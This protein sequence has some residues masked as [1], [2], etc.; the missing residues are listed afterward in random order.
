[1][2]SSQVLWAFWEY[3]RFPYCLFGEVKAFS[4]DPIHAGMVSVKGYGTSLFLPFLITPETQGKVVAEKLQEFRSN[5]DMAI[6]EL[7]LQYDNELKAF[8]DSIHRGN[9]AAKN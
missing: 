5:Q 9:N 4:E 7:K 6:K 1:M 3:D 2:E 8:W